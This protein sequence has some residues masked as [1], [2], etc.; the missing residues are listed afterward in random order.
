M[1]R[2]ELARSVAASFDHQHDVA[3]AD[4]WLAAV[5]LVEG[6]VSRADRLALGAAG[7]LVRSELGGLQYDLAIVLAALAASNGHPDEAAT[8]AGLAAAGVPA[9]RTAAI[10]AMLGPLLPDGAQTSTADAGSAPL[11][12]AIRYAT[13]G[14]AHRAPQ[15]FGWQSLTPTERSVVTLACEG[16][17]N[18]AIGRRLHVGAGTVKTH[19]SH[20]YAKLGIANRTELA[21]AAAQR[22]D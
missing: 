17:T 18:A 20:I 15:R 10:A 11:A 19:L 9:T 2:I 12:D 14:R 7:V 5:A 8:I 16:L 1:T 4:T 6:D 21:T 3:A 22:A 13:R